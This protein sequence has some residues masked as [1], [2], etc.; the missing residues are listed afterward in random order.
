MKRRTILA[1][2]ASWIAGAAFLSAAAPP[3]IWIDVPYV[4]QTK[5]GCG[6]AT[7]SMVMRYWAKQYGQP[8][9]PEMDAAKIQNRLYSPQ[10]KGI[11]GSAMEK[12]F[13]EQG[14]RAFAFRGDW[15]DLQHHLEQGRPLIVC[16]KASGER[17]P[18]HYSVVV[19]LD[20]E[21]AYVFLNDPAVGKM[22]RISHEGFQSEW[23]SA[24]NWTL[25]AV[26]GEAK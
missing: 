14:F 7:I 10:R 24:K 2:L 26:P 5:E 4:S 20:A 16:L 15:N 13:Q 8:V 6:S 17:G 3:A 21:R 11:P 1:S 23:D 18:L 25:L 19:G 12:Y 9:T 22:L